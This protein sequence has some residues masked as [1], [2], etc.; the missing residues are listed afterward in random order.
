MLR[1]W[2]VLLLAGYLTSCGGGGGGGDSSNAPVVTNL[3][4]SPTSATFR[5]GGGTV[6][7]TGYIDFTYPL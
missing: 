2:V 1:I 5:Q 7:V 3:R 6:E 4:F